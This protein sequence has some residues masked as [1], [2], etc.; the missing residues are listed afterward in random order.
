MQNN[1]LRHHTE[2]LK[3]DGFYGII[4]IEIKGAGQTGIGEIERDVEHDEPDRQL[5]K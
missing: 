2:T 5:H 3:M 4:G 1:D